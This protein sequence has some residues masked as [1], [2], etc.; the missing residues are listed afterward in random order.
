MS[1]NTAKTYHFHTVILPPP[2]QQCKALWEVCLYLSL[3][4]SLSLSLLTYLKNHTS[5]FSVNV[6]CG[7]G[8]TFL[9][10]HCNNWCTSSFSDNGAYGGS[11]GTVD[12]SDTMTA[13]RLGIYYLSKMSNILAEGTEPFAVW[14]HIQLRNH[15]VIYYLFIIYLV[16][17]II[18]YYFAHKCAIICNNSCD[19]HRSHLYEVPNRPFQ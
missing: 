15:I 19:K 12:M 16:I 1:P 6:T 9:W 4:L 11:T 2:C 7:Y 17:I 14:L 8:S 13:D 18:I 5:L 10:W 3:S